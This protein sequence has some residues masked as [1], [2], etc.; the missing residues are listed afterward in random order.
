M[1]KEIDVK[2][3]EEIIGYHFKKQALLERA[4]THSSYVNE[5]V[6]LISNERLE[7]L[8]D[9]VL[10]FIVSNELY[11]NTTLNEGR[12]TEIRKPYVC[13]ATLAA[14]VER[15]GLLRFLML[16]RGTLPLSEKTKSNVFEA[17][18]AAIYLDSNGFE[19][20][21]TFITRLLGEINAEF[22]DPKSQLQVYA[23]S[24]KERKKPEYVDEPSGDGAWKSTVSIS[25]KVL[26]EGTGDSK[27]DAQRQAAATALRVLKIN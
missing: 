21:K 5:H 23:Q 12:M 13:K 14:A 8:G 19:E 17:V 24:L 16:G 3:A 18:V 7:F 4:L 20:V 26:G 6:G 25:G 27:K 9:A 22:F 10:G 1:M 11:V 2:Q 15:S